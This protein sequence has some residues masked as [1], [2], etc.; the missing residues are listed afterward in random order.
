MD[1]LLIDSEEFHYSAWVE[2]L[3]PFGID[4]SKRDYLNYAGKQIDMAAEE[5]IKKNNLNAL[6]ENLVSERRNAVFEMFKKNEIDLM[7]HAKE[8]LDFFSN[9]KEIKIGLASGSA[10]KL[11]ELK[12]KNAGIYD[13]FSVIIGGDDVKKGKPAPDVYL[14]AA[15]KLK[16]NPKE[17]LALEDTQFGVEAAKAAGL[18]CFAIPNEYSQ[19]QNFSKADGV[20]NDLKGAIDCVKK[21]AFCFAS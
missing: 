7:P 9:D 14:L 2:V 20:F 13:Y 19:R 4:F 18:F 12:L 10:S 5:I 3:K 21:H 1:G 17:C 11:V 6:K 8:S 16:M 15:E